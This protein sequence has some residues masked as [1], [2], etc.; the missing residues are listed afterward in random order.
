[1]KKIYEELFKLSSKENQNKMEE[2]KNDTEKMNFKL[3]SEKYPYLKNHSGNSTYTFDEDFFKIVFLKDHIEFK[4]IS[5][6]NSNY[7]FKTEIIRPMKKN[8]YEIEFTIFNKENVND[9]LFSSFVFKDNNLVDT[10][11]EDDLSVELNSKM[12][13]NN[14]YPYEGYVF[15]EKDV[16]SIIFDHYLNA[17]ELSDILLLNDIDISN[18]DIL[19]T[20]I[21]QCHMINDCKKNHLK[22]NNYTI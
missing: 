7:K 16:M 2:F 11:F 18:D 15:D 13:N 8:T 19:K 17:N 20:I 22:L 9:R 14:V 21:Q 4:I 10:E 12:S 6:L 3:L 1:M 5:D